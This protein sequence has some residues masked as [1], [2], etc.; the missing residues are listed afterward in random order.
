MITLGHEEKPMKENHGQRKNAA[1]K[2][3][4][5]NEKPRSAEQLMKVHDADWCSKYASIVD[6]A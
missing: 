5:S 3:K 6:V 4:S 2:A 1:M